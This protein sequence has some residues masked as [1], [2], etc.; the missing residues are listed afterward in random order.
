MSTFKTEPIKW[1]V[2]RM[3]CECG[4]E[5]EHRFTVKYKDNP[6]THVCNKCNALEDTDVIYPK[7]KWHDWMATIEALKV[8]NK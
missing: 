8:S 3:M 1:S 2:T 7:T 6:F 5:F 4:G